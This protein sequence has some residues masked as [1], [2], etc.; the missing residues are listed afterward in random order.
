MKH[1]IKYYLAV[2]TALFLMAT[3]STSFAAMGDVNWDQGN[4]VVIGMGIAPPNAVNSEQA[5]MLARRAAVVDGYRQMAEI[6]KGVSVTSETTVENMMVLSD[7]T[8]TRVEATIKG[9]RVTSEQMTPGGGYEVTMVVPMYGVSSSLASAVIEPTIKKEAFPQPVAAVQTSPAPTTSVSTNVTV[10]IPTVTTT[11][12]I[13]NQPAAPTTSSVQANGGYTGLIV[14][15]R[16]LGL[17]PVMTPLVKNDMGD[18]IYG[19]KNIDSA[20]IIQYGMAAYTKDVNNVSR[21]GTNP[22]MVKAIGLDGNSCNPVIT[23]SDAN[24]VLIENSTSHFLD[25]TSVVL[26]RD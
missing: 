2:V 26:L 16:G 13:P 17:Q 1:L 18:T 22:L 24:R 25:R 7:A 11:P 12:T 8:R 10:N 23:T 4:I 3:S 9:A 20:T 21:A 19:R 5:R 6:I 15:C 14:D